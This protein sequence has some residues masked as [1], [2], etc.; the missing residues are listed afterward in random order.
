MEKKYEE[1]IPVRKSPCDE[2]KRKQV[3][4]EKP[5]I[6]YSGD[7]DIKTQKQKILL[8]VFGFCQYRCLSCSYSSTQR[9]QGDFH[10]LFE[11]EIYRSLKHLRH[12]YN[13]VDLRVSL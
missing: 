12:I 11:V 9:S 1:K 8:F 5:S 10:V 7:N 3:F 2:M 6:S 13:Y 4:D